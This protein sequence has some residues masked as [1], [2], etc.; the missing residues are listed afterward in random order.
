MGN[1][2]NQLFFKSNITTIVKN[3]NPCAYYNFR[4]SHPICP[5][6]RGIAKRTT[7]RNDAGSGSEP[8]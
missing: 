5:V 1:I 4:A 7:E 6:E 2:L 3:E 8:R